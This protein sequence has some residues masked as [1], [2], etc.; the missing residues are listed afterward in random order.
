MK[1]KGTILVENIVFIILNVLFLAVLVLFLLKQGS[2]AIVLEQAYSKQI[3]ML[4]DSARPGMV[5]EIDMEKGK[6]LAEDNGI[7]F[8]SS[9]R[10]TGNVVRVRLSERGG[11]TYSFFND[12]SVYP[13]ALKDGKEEYTGMYR[14]TINEKGAEND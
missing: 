8:G 12:V 1:K 7:D 11:Y 5:I 3:S 14:F 13:S 2:G 9:V 6:K 10:I 4:V